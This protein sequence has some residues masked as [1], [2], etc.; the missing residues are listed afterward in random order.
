MIFTNGKLTSFLTTLSNWETTTKNSRLVLTRF[1]LKRFFVLSIKKHQ[2]FGAD[3]LGGNTEQEQFLTLS[4]DCAKKET[5][6]INL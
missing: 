2:L 5:H 4:K 1:A 6:Q 3:V